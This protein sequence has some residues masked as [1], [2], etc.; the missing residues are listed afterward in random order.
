MK[1]RLY[2][3]VW[4]GALILIAAALLLFE[5]QLLW[6]IE[7]TNLFLY[8]PLYFKEQM[9]VPGGLLSYVGCFFTQYL[10]HPWL[11]VFLLC[12]WWWLLMWLTKR[13]F[14]ITNLWAPVA[15]LPVVFLLMMIINL[16]YWVYLLKLHG[17]FFVATIGAPAAVALLWGFRCTP[18]KLWARAVYIALTVI[19][20]YPLL[21]VYALAAALLMGIWSWRLTKGKRTLPI[22]CLA[23]AVVCVLFI[24]MLY[25]RQVY[26]QVSTDNIYW[27]SLPRYFV[28]DR[29]DN[30]YLP[31][32]LLAMF[33]LL[34]TLFYKHENKTVVEQKA[35]TEKKGTTGKKKTTAKKDEKKSRIGATERITILQAV[36][37]I[38]VAIF[39][40]DYWYKDENF[41][42]ELKML[43]DVEWLDWQKVLDEA[44]KQKGEPSRPIVSMRNLALAHLGRQGNE[45]FLFKNGA[46]KANTP[47]PLPPM[48]INGIQL[49][50]QYG[51]V[52]LA[53]RLG[54]E[55]SV[56]FNFRVE[57]L[58]LM[59]KSAILNGE[60]Q[61]ARKFLDLLKQTRF[62]KEW[63][64][65]WE[66]LIGNREAM[67]KDPEMGFITHL[68]HYEN[69]LGSDQGQPERYIMLQL[70][71]NKSDDPVF[72]EQALLATIWL[73]NDMAFWEHLNQYILTHPNGA[74]PRYYQE[75][76]YLFSQIN[77]QVDVS[78]VPFDPGIK[79][80]FTQ[81]MRTAQQY[82]GA[83]MKMTRDD[84][85]PLYGDT[86]YYDYYL[87]TNL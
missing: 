35:I 24:P 40:F 74:L 70:A 20:G 34:M 77:Q 43:H 68:M 1:K 48:I 33:Y 66:K 64:E 38:A 76:A 51:L 14:R 9:L 16:G 42:R 15:V 84:L 46:K 41:H 32:G 3:A 11:G 26:Y 56:E 2:L 31:Y 39:I 27:A 85:Y 53:F 82:E 80:R 47:L 25:Y 71:S 58:K 50:Y 49:Y 57:T 44:A 23:L 60:D 30:Y 62:H 86:Y 54:M 7:E 52:N 21:G 81:F 69:T 45:M 28:I 75:A 55:N 8:S 65:H 12:A 13:C 59:A 72:S 61:L 5:N 18:E 36:A 4:L 37:G 67:E 73:R 6:K 87:M 83:D 79:E 22:V 29:Y 17:Y 19:I 78:N 63:A 10:Y